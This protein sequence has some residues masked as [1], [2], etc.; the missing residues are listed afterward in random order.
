MYISASNHF[1]HKPL[2]F[3][4]VSQQSFLAGDVAVLR[5][6]G[7]DLFCTTLHGFFSESVFRTE[8]GLERLEFDSSKVML[9][10]LDSARGDG[11]AGEEFA[12]FSSDESLTDCEEGC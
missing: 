6:F 5:I 3:Q 4:V 7:E 8:V 9:E 2:Q 12:F 10:R 11:T 1:E